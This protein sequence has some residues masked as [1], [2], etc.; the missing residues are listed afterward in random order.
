MNYYWE[1]IKQSV[2]QKGEAKLFQSILQRDQVLLDRVTSHL[3]VQKI[4]RQKNI[5]S[6]CNRTLHAGC[7]SKSELNECSV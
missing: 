3:R 7:D 2:S 6:T 4:D 1:S 5:L